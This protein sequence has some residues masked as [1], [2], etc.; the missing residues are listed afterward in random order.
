MQ[1]SNVETINERKQ[2]IKGDIA[3]YGGML[4]DARRNPGKY[5]KE[6][7]DRFQN[8]YDRGLAEL[9][10][11]EKKLWRREKRTPA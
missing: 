7:I 3:F 8:W 4:D 5:A 6:E 11:L 10:E 2:R 9:R 1:N